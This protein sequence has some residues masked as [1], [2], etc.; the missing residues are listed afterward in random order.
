MSASSQADSAPDWSGMN[1]GRRKLA[2]GVAAAIAFA[3]LGAALE[4]EF[5]D[6]DHPAPPVIGTGQYGIPK[7]I[8]AVPSGLEPEKGLAVGQSVVALLA[9]DGR[10]VVIGA[11][12]DFRYH[13]L[14]LPKANGKALALSPDGRLLAY[15]STGGVRILDLGTGKLRT[16]IAFSDSPFSD[17]DVSQLDWTPDSRSLVFGGPALG[18]GQGGRALVDMDDWYPGGELAD[19][20]SLWASTEL[21]GFVGVGA[22]DAWFHD[23]ETDWRRR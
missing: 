6:H 15:T 19:L 7:K 3:V 18:Q 17:V 14:D 13:V 5:P 9:D 22:D 2:I 21:G 4:A 20:G 16:D 12:D 11:T 8:V 23:G 1:P 10:R